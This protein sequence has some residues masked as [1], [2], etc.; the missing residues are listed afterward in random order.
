M[1]KRP[2]IS[3]RSPRAQLLEGRG[4]DSQ[5][6]KKFAGLSNSNP[7]ELHSILPSLAPSTFSMYIIDRTQGRGNGKG[8]QCKEESE[9]K[10]GGT[11]SQAEHPAVHAKNA[12]AQSTKDERTQAVGR[13]VPR[14]A[15][16]LPDPSPERTRV[17]RHLSDSA[18]PRVQAL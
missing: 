15:E 18:E 10:T 8:I 12:L 2:K 14:R 17:F 11:S 13:Q 5:I 7:P 3:S 16:L 6:L 9:N 4:G 1:H